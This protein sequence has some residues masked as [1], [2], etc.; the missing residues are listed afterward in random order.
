MGARMD[1]PGAR[2]TMIFDNTPTTGCGP[3]RAECVTLRR[4]ESR[5]SVRNGG[6]RMNVRRR[7]VT[8]FAC[9]VA[10]IASDASANPAERAVNDTCAQAVVL[11]GEG[12]YSGSTNGAATDLLPEQIAGWCQE[13]GR[14]V[15]YQF[16]PAV[17]KGYQIRV[18]GGYNTGVAVY[19]ACD[20]PPIHCNMHC[21]GVMTI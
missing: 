12:A 13:F 9:F 15:W 16:T 20:G 6:S 3:A 10:A 5:A 2:L 11:P 19:G 7:A 17:S 18:E 1:M 14:E 8:V 21:Q 4:T